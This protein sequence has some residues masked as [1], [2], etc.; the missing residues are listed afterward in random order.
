M[1]SPMKSLISG[2]KP[3][4]SPLGLVGWLIAGEQNVSRPDGP[5]VKNV[6]C[7]CPAQSTHPKDVFDQLDG[8]YWLLRS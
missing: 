2:V 1:N 5:R 7:D 6:D 4:P 8:I 3:D